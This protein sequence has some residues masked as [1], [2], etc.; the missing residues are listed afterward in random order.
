MNLTI[1]KFIAVTAL[2]IHLM[3]APVVSEIRDIDIRE[4]SGAADIENSYI[5]KQNSIFMAD[6]DNGT[7]EDKEKTTSGS[8]TK[9]SEAESERVDEEKKSSKEAS[10]PLESFVPSEKI[11]GEQAVDFPVDI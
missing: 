7:S 2:S 6:N 10:K 4:F 8:E 5:S 11:P 3:S 1:I 9:G